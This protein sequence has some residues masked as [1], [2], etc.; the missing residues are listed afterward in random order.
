MADAAA[1]PFRKMLAVAGLALLAACGGSGGTAADT[2]PLDGPIDRSDP[3]ASRP[4]SRTSVVATFQD[5]TE[6]TYTLVLPADYLPGGDYP[7]LLALPPGG[8][9]QS[10]V[11]AVLDGYWAEEAIRRGWIVISPV[12]PGELFFQGGERYLSSLLTQVAV[13]YPPEGG[14]LHVAGISNGGLSAF[15][16]ALD[17]HGSV[18]SLLTI[19]GHPPEER[20]YL[21]LDRLVDTPVALY[22][23]ENDDGWREA[24]E[25]VAAELDRLG[26]TVSVT[27]SPGE[28]HILRNVDPA[29][30]FDF[31]DAARP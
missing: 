25:R 18:L 5:G 6:I 7:I 22:V 13:S 19:P 23:G 8:Q 1:R 29:E 28:G 24:T 10:E 2:E 26:G 27:V 20:D 30:L 9:G 17:N 11:D 15:R 16:Y 31:F 12:A 14:G 4:G 21:A 3:P